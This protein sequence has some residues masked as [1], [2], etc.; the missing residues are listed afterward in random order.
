MKNKNNMQNRLFLSYLFFLILIISFITFVTYN[1]SRNIIIENVGQSRAE[2]LS[3]TADNIN[4]L[5]YSITLAVSLH[6][7]NDELDKILSRPL[8]DDPY[9]QL[10][11]KRKTNQMFEFFLDA[12][13]KLDLSYYTVIYGYNQ[14]FFSTIETSLGK[15]D[16][17]ILADR[18]WYQDVIDNNGK[19]LWVSTYNDRDFLNE[20]RNVFTA[21]RLLKHLKTNE[22]L[23]VLYLNIDESVLYKTYEKSLNQ[24]NEIYILDNLNRI[25]SSE[26]KSK[27]GK[28]INFPINN[29]NYTQN[30][31]NNFY[32]QEVEGEEYLVSYNMLDQTDWK[33]VEITS[34]ESLLAPIHQK[35]KWLFWLL[36]FCIIISTLYSYLIA[37]K[38][39]APISLLSQTMQTVGCGDLSVRF[40]YPDNLSNEIK[41]LGKGFNDM[42]DEINTLISIVRKEEKLKGEAEIKYLQAQINPHFLYNTLNSI[43]C[44]IVMDKKKKA[45]TVMKKLISFLREML[46]LNEVVTVADEFANME[47]YISIEKYKYG[48]F[49]ASFYIEDDLYSA[50]IPKMILQPIVENAI[51][52]GLGQ[53]NEKGNIKIKAEKDNGSL[54]IKVIDDGIGIK[55]DKLNEIN[56]VLED[57]NQEG[58]EH[59]GLANVHQR[60][61]FK[62]GEDY[63]LKVKSNNSLGTEVELRFPL[64]YTQ[65]GGVD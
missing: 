58:S 16:Y 34:L 45:E 54:L 1:I 6:S 25:V 2:V 60:I 51:F 18:S 17:N 64:I 4:S 21:A 52:H 38:I 30:E 39:T 24:T 23:G 32:I 46:N 3:R 65:T 48:N 37:K 31:N 11:T 29:K 12:F 42:I 5:T 33:I 56:K 20:D 62:Y 14:F 43:R 9:E 50:Y 59:I 15:L 35:M 49:N 7:F 40:N 13:E 55:E 26:H 44:L 47:D 22:P 36:V 53:K 27:L 41:E 57:I 28:A 10:I 8:S 19:I 63:G 61:V